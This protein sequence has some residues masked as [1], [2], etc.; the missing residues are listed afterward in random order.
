M[1]IIIFK[2]VDFVFNRVKADVIHSLRL[3]SVDFLINEF[4]TYY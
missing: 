4:N 1:I 2:Y 3:Q